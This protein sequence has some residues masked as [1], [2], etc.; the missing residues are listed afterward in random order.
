[1]AVEVVNLN[2]KSSQLV[3]DVV[4]ALGLKTFDFMYVKELENKL[5]WIEEA[6]RNESEWDGSEFTEITLQ[7]VANKDLINTTNLYV[8]E[9]WKGYVAKHIV[10]AS[11]YVKRYITEIEH[12]VTVDYL[13]DA[14]KESEIK[15]KLQ[16]NMETFGNVDLAQLY[17]DTEHK[18]AKYLSFLIISNS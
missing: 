12:E 7:L 15:I 6:E 10:N 5:L 18:N 11:I 3:C 9:E 2:P 16:L 8:S 13:V 14:G 17:F 1:M 4:T